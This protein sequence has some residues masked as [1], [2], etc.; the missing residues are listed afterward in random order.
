MRPSSHDRLRTK[1]ARARRRR[2]TKN[3]ES[4]W[5]AP[6]ELAEMFDRL[7]KEYAEGDHTA[8]LEG[9]MLLHNQYPGLIPDWLLQAFDRALLEQLQR[10]PH[11]RKNNMLSLLR[12]KAEDYARHHAVEMHVA[13]GL[14]FTRACQ[15]TAQER[16]AKTG[17]HVT[18]GAIRQSYRRIEPTRRNGVVYPEKRA[19]RLIPDFVPD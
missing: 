15:V 8:A 16:G 11:N 4:P 17:V 13:N 3:P 9:T 10:T 19:F 14:T 18:A 5:M 7:R 2:L 1:R 6:T 12:A